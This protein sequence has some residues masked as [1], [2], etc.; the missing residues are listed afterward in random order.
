[1]L[2]A[3]ATSQ[4]ARFLG[5]QIKAQHFDI[6]ITRRRW[7]VNWTVGLFVPEAVIGSGARFA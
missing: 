3:H 6:K 4:A 5:Y 2:V 1:M 7:A